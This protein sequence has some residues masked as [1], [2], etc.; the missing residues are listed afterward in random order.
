FNLFR[1]VDKVFDIKNVNVRKFYNDKRMTEYCPIQN[2]Y[3]SCYS[4]YQRINAIGTY[5]FMELDKNRKLN[6]MDYERHLSYFIMWLSHILYRR[7]E[8]N[9]FTL[10]YIYNK[11]L[12][13]NFGNFN[14]WNLLYNKMYLTNSNI[15]IMNA[16]YLLFQQILDTIKTIQTENIQPHEYTNKALQFN[17][18]YN[19]LFKHINPCGPYRELLNHLK[20]TY[21]KFIKIAKNKNANSE[22]VLNMLI[23]L[24]PKEKRFG[25]KF[26]S[27]GCIKIHNKLNNNTSKLIQIGNSMLKDYAEK[28]TQNTPDLIKSQDTEFYYYYGFDDDD[29]VNGGDGVNDGDDV[30]SGDDAI[31]DDD[32][33]NGDLRNNGITKNRPKAQPHTDPSSTKLPAP[34]QASQQ[35]G[36]SPQSGTNDSD[37]GQG[38]SK[39]EKTD[40]GT[41]KGNSDSEGGKK[42]GTKGESGSTVGGSGSGTGDTSGGQSDQGGSSGGSDSQGD[43]APTHPSGEPNGYLS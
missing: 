3:K 12:K 34:L 43:Q 17:V 15:A 33:E 21:N 24:S 10:N 28:K 5:V 30:N 22:D 25:H 42:G 8:D 41:Q 39:S 9:T 6:G 4:D 27:K 40:S 1:E 38:A 2:G 16:L 7:F 32:D 29:D 23:E 18:I 36:T 13:N 26:N 11:H 35:S 19:K 37:K 14:Y 20:T 31:D